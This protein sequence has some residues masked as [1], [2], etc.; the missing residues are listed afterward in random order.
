MAAGD[1]KLFRVGVGL[2]QY[3]S[4]G[5][6]ATTNEDIWVP[7][8]SASSSSVAESTLVAGR[9]ALAGVNFTRPADV[10]AYA[11]LDVVSNSTSVGAVLTFTNL[12]RTI[13]GSGYITK[14]RI[15]TNQSTNTAR[16]RLHLFETSPDA[17][18]SRNDNVPFTQLFANRALAIGVID[19]PAMV[20][21]GAGSDAARSM[22]ADIRLGFSGSATANIFG[23]LETLDAFTPANAQQFYVELIA[24]QN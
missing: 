2:T 3:V 7:Q 11:A 14:A 13:G 12:A 18:S 16:F 22:N 24:E 1:K 23:I 19:F 20:T 9:T 4:I 21:E 17:S 8:I 15:I 6:D 10:S 5:I